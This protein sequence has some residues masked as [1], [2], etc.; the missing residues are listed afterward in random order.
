[1][2]MTGYEDISGDINSG[3]C[4]EGRVVPLKAEFQQFTGNA[5]LGATLEEGA[6]IA[7]A[8]CEPMGQE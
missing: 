1:M 6:T 4:F 5:V 2:I 8:E 3:E 7:D